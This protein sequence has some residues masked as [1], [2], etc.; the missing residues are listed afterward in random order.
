MSVVMTT[1]V[2]HRPDP[3]ESHATSAAMHVARSRS[4]RTNR[5][6]AR[7]TINHYGYLDPSILPSADRE[8]ASAGAAASLAHA[9]YTTRQINKLDTEHPLRNPQLTPA[10]S[11]AAYLAG[12][13]RNAKSPDEKHI[14]QGNKPTSNAGAR[15]AATGALSRS[16]TRAESAPPGP[17]KSDHLTHALT[18]AS[19]SHRM[20]LGPTVVPE[21]YEVPLDVR[22]IHET[23]VANT[24]RELHPEK[25]ILHEKAVVMARQMFSVM[26]QTEAVLPSVTSRRSG[27][28]TMVRPLSLHETAQR[29]AS[30]TLA[31]MDDEQKAFRDYYNATIPPKRQSSIYSK[32]RKR[33]ASD[34]R[35]MDMDLEQPAKIRSQM[36][37]LHGKMAKVDA[38]KMARDREALMRAAKKNAD[39]AIYN[40]ERRIYES[41]GRPQPREI[42]KY[43]TRPAKD[44]DSKPIPIG[45]GRFVTQGEVDRLAQSK[46]KPTIDDLTR[47][48]EEQ[49]AREIEEELD[50]RQARRQ[51]ELER[52]REEEVK[53]SLEDATGVEKKSIKSE[54]D[55][56]KRLNRLSRTSGISIFRHKSGKAREKTPSK[57][58]VAASAPL[59]DHHAQQDEEA[60]EDQ[61]HPNQKPNSQ[62]RSH[63][64]T[65]STGESS[66]SVLLEPAPNN[67]PRQPSTASNRTQSVPSEKSAPKLILWPKKKKKKREGQEDRPS[68]PNQIVGVGAG[69][70][71]S[72]DAT[73]RRESAP[74]VPPTAAPAVAPTNGAPGIEDNPTFLAVRPA[75]RQWSSSTEGSGVV[76]EQP[77]QTQSGDLARR[78]SVKPKWHLRFLG[79]SSRRSTSGAAP[80][81]FEVQREHAIIPPPGAT[82]VTT[83]PDGTSEP[84]R[85]IPSQELSANTPATNPSKFTENL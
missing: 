37:R 10:S 61:T 62:P 31:T 64:G 77:Q 46:T 85:S 3:T 76:A 19:A 41:T 23:A 47:R 50:E 33:S 63:I 84:T 27:T 11:Q 75:A 7:G 58:E 72:G 42:E 71:R 80:G 53:K 5:A 79:K 12:R 73:V 34:S 67:L 45:A 59:H 8:L 69:G 36:T 20:S 21:E 81:S 35:V 13:S 24:Q 66:R 57:E 44:E 14:S 38:E 78:R 43:L 18:A 22:K 40:V 29:L 16:R 65:A 28:T 25:N 55:S 60:I 74:A 56:E 52:E 51:H 49:R 30:E 2:R 26:P 9:G 39:A 15:L 32:Y 82:S 1:Q 70:I 48:L 6:G 17:D 83:R 54:K 68:S 4:N